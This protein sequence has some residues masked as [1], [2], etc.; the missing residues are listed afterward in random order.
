MRKH[1]FWIWLSTL[2]LLNLLAHWFFFRI[3]LTN[4]K[5]YSLSEETK[6][7]LRQVDRVEID[8]F[9]DGGGLN[10]GFLRLKEATIQLLREF[11]VY[12]SVQ[13]S[14][15]DPAKMTEQEKQALAQ[16][17]GQYG[18]IPTAVFERDKSGK[19]SETIVYP[20]ARLRYGNKATI[21]CLLQN[22]RGLS[23]AENLNHSIESLEYLFAESIQTLTQTEQNK[24]VF[25]EGHGELTEHLT[26][27]IQSLASPYFDIY[28]GTLTNDVS[29]LNPFKAVVIADPQQPFSEQDKYIIDQY[30]MHGGAVLWAINGVRLSEEVL[31][32]NGFTPILP[33]DLN[34]QDM[35]FR[36]G[37]R[38]NPCLIADLQCLSIPVDISR[39]PTKPQYEPIPW[40]YAPLLL[41]SAASPITHNIMQV[42]STFVSNIDL[43]G[44]SATQKRI[45]LLATSSI[46]RLI[47]TPAEI[48]LS[49]LSINPQAFTRSYIP[50]AVSIEGQFS[51]LFAH[52]MLPEGL[53]TQTEKKT[54]TAYAKQIIVASGSILQN[55]WQ[56]GQP[57]P[58]GYDRYSKMQFGNR[59]FFLNSLLWLT[60]QTGLVNLRQKTIPLRLLNTTL[61]N[62][63]RNIYTVYAIVL[64]LLCL[65]ITAMAVLTTRRFKYKH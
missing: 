41:T 51:S 56:N 65:A 58:C 1:A 2:V 55:D 14:V 31:S 5:R 29:C 17:L 6:D 21:I 10:S 63:K 48:D 60:D 26:A 4:D 47:G 59:D 24:I 28:R 22:N 43:V 11:D 16:E 20:Y 23:G 44:D 9:L 45:V 35:L 39:D 8:L 12:G 46:S 42:S 30:I 62:E 38:V 40:C 25:L 33:L 19:T 37:V 18:Y 53:I 27:D 34:I 52:R 54:E 7:M 13:C 15:C 61:V 32:Q 50:V 57:L 49:D 64:P 3:D 36:Y